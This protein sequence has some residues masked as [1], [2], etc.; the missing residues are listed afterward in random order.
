M[1]SGGHVRERVRQHERSLQHVAGAHPMGD[2]DHAGV[3]GDRRDHAVTR[4]DKV[5]L[6]P[7]VG[8]EGD[9]H[10]RER[11]ASTSPSRS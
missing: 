3:G 11:N 1:D 6:Q 2:V 9:D 5:V 10:E 4:A 7:E 8:Q